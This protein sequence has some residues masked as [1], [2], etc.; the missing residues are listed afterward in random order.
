MGTTAWKRL[1]RITQ[2]VATPF[3]LL[4][5]LLLTAVGWFAGVVSDAITL[6]VAIFVSAAA[7]IFGS[8]WRLPMTLDRE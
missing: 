8:R 3:A 7:V 5:L 4:I 1:T 2:C 6:L